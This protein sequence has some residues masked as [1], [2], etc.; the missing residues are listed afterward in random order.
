MNQVLLIGLPVDWK[1]WIVFLLIIALVIVWL[2]TLLEISQA[3]FKNRIF[4]IAWFLFV[5][6]TGIVGVLVYR[7]WA[8]PRPSALM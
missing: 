4:N 7:A 1:E 8:R 6:F 2:K 3:L 5:L